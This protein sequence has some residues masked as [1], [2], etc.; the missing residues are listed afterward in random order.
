MEAG[1]DE[2]E[3]EEETQYEEEQI[4]GAGSPE[5]R[6]EEGGR[7]VRNKAQGVCPD[8]IEELDECEGEVEEEEAEEV[9]GVGVSQDEPDPGGLQEGLQRGTRNCSTQTQT[10]K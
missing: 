6:E 3:E 8:P 10:Y 2:E 4:I 7:P 9:P 1:G 5:Y